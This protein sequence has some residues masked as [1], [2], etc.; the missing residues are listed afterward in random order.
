MDMKLVRLSLIL[1][2]VSV[3]ECC[4]LDSSAK[5][6]DE[7]KC[8]VP[9]PIQ[10]GVYF[11][12]LCPDSKR[13]FLDQLIPAYNDIGGIMQLNLVPFGHA[14]VL[15]PNKMICQHGA[16]ECDGN[17]LMACIATQ[18]GATDKNS[19]ETIGCVFESKNAPEECVNKYLGAD[20]YSEVE[21]CKNSTDSYR[22]MVTYA[23]ETGRPSY[24]PH[25]KFNGEH[26]EA[27]QEGLEFNLKRYVCEHFNGTKP[28]GCNDLPRIKKR[29][30]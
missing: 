15:G 7:D 11:E 20:S 21:K 3:L 16:R 23:A 10:L 6:N 9:N 28:N 1:L 8:S 13:F 5:Q 24:V 12:S 29:Y 18:P 26:S 14:R 17:R 30:Y 25:L 19:L 2:M 4:H 22:L 27:I